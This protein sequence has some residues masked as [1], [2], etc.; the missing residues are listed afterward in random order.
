MLTIDVCDHLVLCKYYRSLYDMIIDYTVMQSSTANP[1]LFA[2]SPRI[3][4]PIAMWH[5]VAS[6]LKNE[7]G[8][9]GI[10]IGRL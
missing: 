9:K 7:F 10:C 5:S 2:I 6:N 3:G 1:I 4:N 8:T